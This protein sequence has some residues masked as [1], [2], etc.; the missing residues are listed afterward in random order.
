[1]APGSAAD[2]E[3]AEEAYV[4]KALVRLA[5]EWSGR[6]GFCHSRLRIGSEIPRRGGPPTGS[7]RS[8]LLAAVPWDCYASPFAKI[9]STRWRM[10]PLR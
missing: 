5:L 10:P 1:M 9:R 4:A 7:H 8:S 2:A 6:E 3:G